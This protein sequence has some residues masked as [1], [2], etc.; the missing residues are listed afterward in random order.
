M[1]G[2]LFI[3]LVS[4]T[5][6]SEETL[7]QFSIDNIFIS[8]GIDF[9]D[10]HK[11]NFDLQD[12]SMSFLW[13]KEKSLSGIVRL[14]SQ[15]LMN[16]PAIFKSQVLDELGTYEAYVQYEGVIY[17]R[18]RMGLIPIEFSIEGRTQEYQMDL[19]RSLL[20]SQ[21]I[22]GL[23]DYG[24]S[25]FIENQGFYTQLAVHNGE[26]GENL[27]GR[28]YYTA[29]WGWSDQ[30]RMDIGISGHT[31]VSQPE[32]TLLQSS[33][34]GGVD[35]SLK[36]Q[37]K[38]WGPYLHWTPDNW[39]LLIEYMQGELEQK[40]NPQADQ[41]RSGHLDLSYTLS[42]KFKFMARYDHFDSRF[43][44]KEDYQRELSL[45]LVFLGRHGNSRLILLATKVTDSSHTL[46]DRYSLTWKITPK[47]L[48]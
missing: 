21:R 48:P 9:I 36:A 46:G 45:S 19:P 17:G 27:D 6:F 2:F 20:F 33:N 32:S 34:L 7:G 47:V 26:A 40:Q 1:I 37:W 10:S 43:K 4:P 23:R 3:F 24:L 14:G 28:V 44:V 5:S 12:S 15:S 22:I 29:S 42:G 13:T 30:H 35:L 18:L 38:M 31:G 16:P 39:D 41:F 8:T 25:Y 11:G